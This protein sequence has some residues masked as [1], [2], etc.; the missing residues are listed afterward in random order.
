MTTSNVLFEI[1][2][3][4]MPARFLTDTEKQLSEKT[5]AWLDE[6]RL[7]YEKMDTFITPRRFAVLIHNLE[8]KQPDLHEEVRGPKLQIAKDQAGDWSKAAIGF[9]K[10]QGKTVEDIVVKTV[11]GH[12]YIFVEKYTEGQ[13]ATAILPDFKD[14]V[15]SLNFP[16]NMRWGDRSL[17]FI[18]PIKWILALNDTDVIPFEIEE[19]VSSNDTRGHR[20]LGHTITISDALSYQAALKDEY[21]IASTTERQAMIVEQI[22][23]LETAQDFVVPID[24]DLLEEVT[25]LV[26]Y[27]TVFYGEFSKDFLDVP[28]EAL[29]TSMKEHQRYFPVRQTD[30]TLLPYFI[31]V[32]NGNDDHIDTVKRGNEKVLNARLKDA[33]FF[34]EEDQKQSI[35]ANNDKLTRMVFQE[36]LGTLHDKVER[37]TAISQSVAIAL[38]FDQAVVK[39]VHRA[40]HI[41]KFDL[42]TQMV[43]EFTN[44]Q[45]VMGEKYARLKGESEAVSVALNEQYMPRHAHDAL[46][47]STVGQILSV[48][49]KMDTIV[50]C[51]AVGLMPTGSQD[52]YALR[53]QAMGVVQILERFGWSLSFEDL[54]DLIVSHYETTAIAVNDYDVVK[55]NVTDFFRARVSYIAKERGVERDIIEAVTS[56]GLGQLHQLFIKANLLEDSRKDE[57]FKETE[58][59][60]V[61]SL[62]LAKKATTTEVEA[63]LFDNESETALYQTLLE[64]RAS[65][66]A[67][68][69]EEAY[70]EAL[71]ELEALTPAINRFF[72]E[73][74]VMVDNDKVKN[75]RLALLNQVKQLVD[76]LGDFTQIEWK[77]QF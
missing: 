33:V 29:I 60:L 13:L 67:R 15:L 61:R 21:V 68:I 4:E 27:P 11:D 42:V 49:D 47:V 64:V 16:K 50:G 32:R 51:I 52:P 41:S 38:Q 48:A 18:R 9:C 6:S 69:K 5:A 44:L 45:G 30:H 40:A 72:D 54:L 65:F 22:K 19:V 74:M 58:E 37:V 14:V 53:R 56:L 17:R 66:E 20:F 73:T 31:A 62:N 28:E 46:P 39:D 26:E 3:E 1:G 8:S 59:A 24:E 43:N 63:H 2:L 55:H 36:K 12:E 70:K 35:E 75:N 71:E 10:G 23:A 57:A 76:Q 34:Y 77:Q 25:H 7:A